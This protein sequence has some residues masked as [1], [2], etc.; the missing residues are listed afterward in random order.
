MGEITEYLKE[1]YAKSHNS[2][3]QEL[4][5]KQRVK[6][7]ILSACDTHLKE[8]GDKLLFEVVG[9]DLQYVAIVVIEEPLKSKYEISQESDSLFSAKL[10]EIEL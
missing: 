7:S 2:Q 3:T 1:K 4:I 8:A 9:K 6:N 5:N 10:R